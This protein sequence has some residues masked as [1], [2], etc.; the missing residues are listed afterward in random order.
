MNYI[1]TLLIG[2]NLGAAGKGFSDH[3]FDRMWGDLAV[4]SVII[5]V[6]IGFNIFWWYVEKEKKNDKTS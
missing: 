3:D 4:A 2:L 5:V 1:W 6:A